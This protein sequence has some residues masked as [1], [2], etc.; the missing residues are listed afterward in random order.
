MMSGGE[1]WLETLKIKQFFKFKTTNKFLPSPGG[2]MY[3]TRGLARTSPSWT[4]PIASLLALPS[5]PIAITIDQIE[6][7]TKKNDKSIKKQILFT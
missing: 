4:M 3:V 7:Q 2:V 6:A 5:N 1:S